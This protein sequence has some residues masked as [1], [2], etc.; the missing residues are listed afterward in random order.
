MP[1]VIQCNPCGFYFSLYA[2][3]GGY[4][5]GVASLFLSITNHLKSIDIC[6]R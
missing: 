1:S 2:S 4:A 6:V 5:M 3:I